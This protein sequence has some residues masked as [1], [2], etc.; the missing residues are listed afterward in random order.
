[1]PQQSKENE[2]Q[3][4][5]V[6]KGSQKLANQEKQTKPKEEVAQNKVKNTNIPQ[7]QSTQAKKENKQQKIKQ[8]L[9]VQQD[10]DDNDDEWVEVGNKK[11]QVIR[12]QKKEEEVQVQQQNQQP[13]KNQVIQQ[14]PSKPSVQT[15][16]QDPPKVEST[17]SSKNQSRKEK[18]QKQKVE[19]PVEEDDDEWDTVEKKQPKK[20]DRAQG[21]EQTDYNN[22]QNS[23]G[24]F[25]K[26]E[27]RKLKDYQKQIEEAYKQRIQQIDDIHHLK[28][29]SK[30]TQY[31]IKN[32]DQVLN[33][34]NVVS[35]PEIDLKIP[36][37][38][39][40][41]YSREE[42]DKL[43]QAKMPKPKNVVSNDVF[44][45][46][47]EPI[48]VQPKKSQQA[49]PIVLK[50]KL[51]LF[52][53]LQQEQKQKEQLIYTD[54]SISFIVNK[55]KQRPF[56]SGQIELPANT[57]GKDLFGRVKK[58]RRPTQVKKLSEIKQS[59]QQFIADGNDNFE[60]ILQDLGKAVLPGYKTLDEEGRIK[61]IRDS[62]Q[63]QYR[64]D[65]ENLLE[66]ETVEL[67][68]R[69]S[70]EIIHQEYIQLVNKFRELRRKSLQE[71]KYEEYISIIKEM[72]EEIY[73]LSTRGTHI[74]MQSLNISEEDYHKSFLFYSQQPE[75]VSQLAFFDQNLK[76]ILPAKFALN[77]KQGIE[78]IRF[79]IDVIEHHESNQQFN[80]VM[81]I[82]HSQ[83]DGDNKEIMAILLNSLIDD[84]IYQKYGYEEEDKIRFMK[85][86]D[87]DSEIQ[88]LQMRL[89]HLVEKV[90]GAQQV[91]Y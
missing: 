70:R 86:F 23:R 49:D 2:V 56:F 85:Q 26:D 82:F 79:K 66:E 91:E 81:K 10:N 31:E 34:Q 46:K 51:T 64:Q 33:T 38:Q 68:L 4:V 45:E 42:I 15:N 57:T 27:Y 72:D 12:P 37:V 30:L 74:I 20:K 71:R 29:I 50:S 16:K 62:V 7:A 9:L 48:Q 25:T 17:E 3:K 75:F 44:V 65:A 41:Q 83:E 69:G 36:D 32:A 47:S 19:E 35:I 89:E 53:P 90:Q 8:P 5:V 14:Q 67:I 54:P 55:D 43:V 18:K 28:K 13:Q 52:K 6:K 39:P 63:V 22:Q 58:Y 60:P 78:L 88:G 87:K 21:D 77:K 59:N 80:S 61:L 40:K 11:K 76:E 24:L 84:I 1:M 73:Q